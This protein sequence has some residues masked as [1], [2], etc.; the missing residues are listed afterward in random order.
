VYVPSGATDVGETEPL[1]KFRVVHPAGV[2][3]GVGV[4]VVEVLVIISTASSHPEGGTKFFVCEV[5]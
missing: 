2:G 4:G 3:V 1:M 5:V